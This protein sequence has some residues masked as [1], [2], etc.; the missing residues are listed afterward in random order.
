MSQPGLLNRIH[1][2]C[3]IIPE[4]DRTAIC[5]KWLGNQNF[6]LA[7]KAD[8]A[9]ARAVAG[10]KATFWAAGWGNGQLPSAE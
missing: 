1:R 10:I 6:Q 8:L 3:I 5:Q 7:T 9:S 2:I 4:V